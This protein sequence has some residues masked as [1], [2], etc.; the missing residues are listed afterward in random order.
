MISTLAFVLTQICHCIAWLLYH[1]PPKA[2]RH[3]CVTV[4]I[5]CAIRST[6]QVLKV[7]RKRTLLIGLDS[8]HTNERDYYLVMICN[9]LLLDSQYTCMWSWVDQQSRQW[10][11]VC[12]SRRSPPPLENKNI[13]WYMGAFLKLFLMW[14]LLTTF[15]LHVGA[16]LFFM[17]LP[18]PLLKISVGTH[19]PAMFISMQALLT[20]VRLYTEELGR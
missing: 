16:F 18:P 17:S 6:T 20:C 9:D 13:F 14:R 5:T 10:G 7:L 3:R 19:C 15:F 8:F 11:R 1:S 4:K 12:K 2:T